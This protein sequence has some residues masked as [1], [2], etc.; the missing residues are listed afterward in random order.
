M[1]KI[2]GYKTLSNGERVKM[3]EDEAS[4]LW[5]A[6]Q[7]AKA[8][9]AATLPTSQDAVSAVSAA[10]QRMRDLGWSKGIKF[11]H[12][13]K[14]ITEFGVRE[15]GS[16]GI[17]H[18]TLMKEQSLVLYADSVSKPDDVWLKPLDE[19]SKDELDQMKQC[20]EDNQQ[21]VDAFHARW[22]VVDFDAQ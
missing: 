15:T 20:D 4:E 14:N 3:S 8:N 21:L 13:A 19:L 16:T 9:L 2:K 1:T 7:D 17:W 12:R 11:T 5:N 6:A 22:S 10:L 18:G